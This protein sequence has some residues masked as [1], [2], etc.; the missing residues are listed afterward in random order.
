MKKQHFKETLV[1]PR[2]MVPLVNGEE[3]RRGEATVAV[4]VRETEQAL[5]VTGMPAAVGA[6][7]AG[8]RLL[9]LTGSHHVTC[10]GTN[11]KIDN[12]QVATAAG[13]PIGAY[14]LGELIVVASTGG[15]TYLAN[16]GGAWHVLD[17]DDAVPQ[18]A[19]AEQLTT[20]TTDID[21]YTFADAYPLWQAP[22]ARAD[23]TA[24]TAMLRNAWT[25]LVSD[26]AA[27]GTHTAPM[28][29]RWAVRLHDD[30][31]LWMSEP[32]RVGDAT[33]ANVQSIIATVDSDSDGF[34][35]IQSSVMSML[36]YTL[37]ITVNRG[38]ADDWLPLVKSIDVLATDEATL[39]SSTRSLEYRCITRTTGERE[40]L[41]EMGLARRGTDAITRQLN[42]SPWHL[43]VS[44]PATTSMSGS[45]F[46][47][48]TQNLTLT[49]EQCDA[50]GAMTRVEG[51]VCATAAAGR[52][53]CCTAGGEIL[54]SVPGNALAVAHRRNVF[55]AEPLAMAVVTK[56]L[57]SGGFGRYPVYVFTDDGVYAIPQSAMGTLGEARLVDR[58]II[59]AAV[60]PVEGGGDVWFVSRH[61]QLCRL[62]GANVS[63]AVRHLSCSALAWCNAHGELWLLPAQGNPVVRL[64]SGAMSERTVAAVQ[65]YSDARHAVAVTGD[66]TIVDLEQ[67]QASSMPV[68]WLSHPVALSPL[69]GSSLGRVVWHLS[70]P[71]VDLSLQV[72]GQRGIMAQDR[73]VSV[74]TVTGACD[75]P[76]ATAPMAVR[77]RTVRLRATG[78]AAT[79][80]LLL[81][82]LLYWR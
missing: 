65:L 43:I 18:L 79:G 82:T 61:S 15:F 7:A 25:A 78:S 21:A 32:V 27:D 23:I 46:A 59:D 72:L 11:V 64:R 9:L 13:R 6:M 8:D 2:A 57:Y 22:L 38:I 1:L 44:A 50:V 62:S 53:Y 75:Q 16:R 12:V 77:A 47:P 80:T 52:L 51:M 17:P 4:N 42:A 26:A 60:S 48:T 76:L 34:T 20:A 45:D 33:L 24:L 67:E 28:L 69:L 41:L 19:F 5:V 55:G 63:V 73:D 74:I 58:T 30:S 56:P 70:G 66:G 29:V 3:A 14:A 40:H 81:P 68:S 37:G 49:G 10:R 35:G 31:Y 39:L 36:R 71:S 54:V